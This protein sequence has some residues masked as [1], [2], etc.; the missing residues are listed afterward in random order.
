MQQPWLARPLLQL[1]KK[2]GNKKCNC[3][4]NGWPYLSVVSLTTLSLAF[5]RANLFVARSTFAICVRRVWC[6]PYY[7]IQPFSFVLSFEG[8]CRFSVKMFTLGEW[9]HPIFVELI[10]F[11]NI[12]VKV[13]HSNNWLV[14]PLTCFHLCNNTALLL[15]QQTEGRQCYY[16][17]GGNS[18]TAASQELIKLRR[19]AFTVES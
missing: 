1:P 16:L 11:D 4:H 8:L 2:S 9:W 13:I 3:C 17:C 19:R 15:F 12:T 5:S 6:S 18:L 10:L 7:P 14:R